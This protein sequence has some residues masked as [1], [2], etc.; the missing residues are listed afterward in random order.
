MCVFHNKYIEPEL[1]G[2]YTNQINV[3]QE[4]QVQFFLSV[5]QFSFRANRKCE[6]LNICIRKLPFFK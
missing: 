4:L 3:H 5:V 2:S 6:K 1:E